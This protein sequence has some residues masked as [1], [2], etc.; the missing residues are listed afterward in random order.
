MLPLEDKSIPLES[1]TYIS[2]LVVTNPLSSDLAATADDHL[3]L[4]K[5]TIK[6]TFPNVNGAITATD[7]EINFVDGVT[8]AIQTQLDSK[9]GIG[10]N[11]SVSASL[12]FTGPTQ[13]TGTASFAINL[14]VS[15]SES[16]GTVDLR[17]SNESNTASSRARLTTRV[18]GTSAEDAIV[19]YEIS[20]GQQYT[21]GID[22]SDSDTFKIQ[23]GASLSASAGLS[24]TT[25]NVVRYDNKEVGFRSGEAR[26]STG[27]VTLELEDR[28]RVLSVDNTVTVPAN[29][30]VA[31]PTW[32]IVTIYNSTGGNIT[33]SPAG[34]VTLALAGTATTGA[35]TLAQFD[36]ATLLKVSTDSW[37]AKGVT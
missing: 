2:D 17:V 20:G 31:F 8:A 30:S 4:I 7:E 24:I 15:R 36:T 26:V 14:G 19:N 25:G 28:G 16:G 32:S 35:R 3:R 12:I 37:I 23:G 10:A 27:T 21:S 11:G 9:L 22:N 5:S 1:G 6:T 18:A 13:F 33:I 29:A 34:G